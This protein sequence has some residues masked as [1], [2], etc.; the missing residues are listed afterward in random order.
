MMHQLTLAEIARALA[1][2]QFSA[3]ELT[4][5]LLTRIQQLD[6]Q[7][8][9]FITV[10]ADQAIEQAKAAD[11]RRAAGENGALLG[12]PI[13]H[14]DLFCTQDV[15]TTCG[16]KILTGFKAPY[17]ATVVEK[18][19]SAGAV[20]L[21]K[22]NMDEF[23]MGSA[24]ESSHYGAVK[25]P[26]DLTRVPGGSSGGSAAAV[27]ARLLPAATGTDTGGSI[28][29]PAALTN[30]TGIKPT[31]GRVSRWGMIAYASSLDQGGP[32]ARTA[33][34]CALMLQAMAGFDTKDSTS[35][36]QPIDDYLAALS[37]PL[38]G[39]RIGLPKE[40]F[41]TGLDA[42]IGEKVMAVVE[43]LKKLGATVKDISLPNMQHAIPAYYVIAPAEA[44]SNLSR[45]DGVRFGYR[46]ENPVNLED[47][48]KRSRGEGFGAEVKR[49][50]MVGTYALSAGYYDA[51][52][53]KAQKI[54]RL[55]KNDFV[56]AFNDVDVILGP[57]TPNLAW[58]L[59]EKNNDPVAAYL[60]D[61]YTITANLAGIPGLSM[62]AGFVEGLPVGVQLLGNYFQEGRL[63]NVAH[64]Y[65][66]VSDWHKQTPN[67]F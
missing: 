62:P 44:S 18:L 53:L 10:T 42:R 1:A 64:Q 55:I 11:A 27:A 12:A 34:D 56:T 5:G 22:L 17:N 35:V 38:A 52:Y 14:K 43:E 3:E 49:R 40:Y 67:G 6:P 29:Q 21:G 19:A 13:G 58:K 15:L 65:Q 33:E 39:L 20:T 57:T 41:G 59:G 23:A 54:R 63:L 66:Q 16:S 46:C 25:N 4:R 36:D 37:Q 32:L 26:W 51:Y 8:N 31:Y 2:K 9:S 30:L 28:R 45:F 7:L 47:L 50:I 61:I 48:Y 60:E 24:N